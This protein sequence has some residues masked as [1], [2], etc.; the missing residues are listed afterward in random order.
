[1]EHGVH[2]SVPKI[3]EILAEKY[4]IRSRWKKNKPRGLIPQAVKPR[5]VIQMDTIDFGELFAFTAIDTFSKEA[6]FS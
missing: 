2:L 6:I 3:Y 5:Q 1:M 4:A